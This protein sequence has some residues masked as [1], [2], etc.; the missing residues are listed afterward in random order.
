[1][2]SIG[3]FRV[4][5]DVYFYL[6]ERIDPNGLSALNISHDRSIVPHLGW[7]VY[8]LNSVDGHS[9][10]VSNPIRRQM[11]LRTSND[12]KDAVTILRIRHAEY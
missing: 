9:P 7:A 11:I 5:F 3:P 1:M 6:S 2:L 12:I 8:V 10:E 4:D